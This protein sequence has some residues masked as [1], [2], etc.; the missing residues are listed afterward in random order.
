[1]DLKFQL[2]GLQ[3]TLMKGIDVFEKSIS[4]KK[5]LAILEEIQEKFHTKKEHAV[6]LGV[7]ITIQS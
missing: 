2:C 1:M 4:V 7:V 6:N 5:I 3:E